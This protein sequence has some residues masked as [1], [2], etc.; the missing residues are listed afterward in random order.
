MKRTLLKGD[1]IY[2]PD[3]DKFIIHKDSYLVIEDGLVSMIT[4]RIDKINEEDDFED[5][6]G[7]LIIPGFVDLHLHAP[8][9]PNKGIGMD[10]ELIPWLD[11]YTFPEESKYSDLNYSR[12][13]FERFIRDLWIVGTTRSVVF[14]TV[15]LDSTKLLMSM[16]I[17]SGL[18]A[19]VGKVNMDQNTIPAMEEDTRKSLEETEEL[20]LEYMGKFDLVKPIIT[21]RFIPTC[22][23]ELLTGLGYL[24]HKYNAPVQ[25]HVNENTDEVEWVKELYPEI[26]SY[27]H[28]YDHFGLFGHTKT[29]MAHCIHNTDEE[30]EL[31]ARNGVYAAHCPYSN[32]N[33]SSGMMPARK[34]LNA[35]VKIGLGSDISGGHELSIPKVMTKAIH[36]SKMIWLKSNK[37]H[38]PLTL[39]EVFYLATKGGGSFFGKVGSF[40]EGY[41]CDALIVDV[42]NLLTEKPLSLEEKLEKFIYTGDERNIIERYVKGRKV[43]EPFK[44]N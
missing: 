37:A 5:Y 34:Y 6:T 36:T 22:S 30:T 31:M 33:L 43:E 17:E 35:G 14:S 38:H 19:Y 44:Q 8:Q 13:V 32:F 7:K 12:L 39:S 16:F 40:E 3:K 18:G 26:K 21:P 15:F 41:E 27:A 10:M 2:T 23:T 20:L 9:Y 24:A 42:S 25:S 28:V 1:I 4:N 11:N 29:V